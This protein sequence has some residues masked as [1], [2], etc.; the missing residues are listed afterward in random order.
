MEEWWYHTEPVYGGR[1]GGVFWACGTFGWWRYLGGN[2]KYSEIWMRGWTGE[3]D[4]SVSVSTWMVV[5]TVRWCISQPGQT[6]SVGVGGRYTVEWVRHGLK[7]QSAWIHI[8]IPL[9]IGNV[10]QVKITSLNFSDFTCKL[11]II[12]VLIF[13]RLLKR[14]TE[15]DDLRKNA[16]DLCLARRKISKNV[17]CGGSG[18]GSRVIWVLKCC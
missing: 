1:W 2:W 18:G 3:I 11:E 8:L 15:M 12:K 4:L 7:G 14:M 9:L 17:C 6:W 10:G 16:L 13:I 5:E